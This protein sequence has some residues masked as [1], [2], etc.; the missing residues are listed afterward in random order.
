MHIGTFVKSLAIKVALCPKNASS[1][2]RR[3]MCLWERGILTAGDV[4]RIFL[5]QGLKHS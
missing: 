4:E 1:K 3:V 5:D 2:K